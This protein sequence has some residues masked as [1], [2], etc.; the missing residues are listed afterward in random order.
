M[1]TMLENVQ[2]K[3]I[4]VLHT[5]ITKYSLEAFALLIAVLY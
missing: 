3:R 5:Y 2:H 1:N 4:K